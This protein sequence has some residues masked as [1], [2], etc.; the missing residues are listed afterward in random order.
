MT[1]YIVCWAYFS[2]NPHTFPL[3][4]FLHPI[5]PW[6]PKQFHSTLSYMHTWF[7]VSVHNVWPTFYIYKIYGPQVRE[8]IWCLSFL[9]WLSPILHP[10]CK[11]DNLFFAAGTIPFC[12]YK[13]HF[14]YVFLYSWSSSFVGHVCRWHGH[15]LVKTPTPQTHGEGQTLP[16]PRCRAMPKLP[17]PNANAD[18]MLRKWPP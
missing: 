4:S 18:N 3:L 17:G 6:S 16:Q 5:S 11:Q 8:S 1:R 2:L 13:T 12:I 7:H 15:E 14:A 10:S 9:T